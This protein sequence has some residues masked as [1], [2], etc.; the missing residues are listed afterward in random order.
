MKK[1]SSKKT[2]S[3]PRHN[4]ERE[5]RVLLEKMHSEIKNIG[6]G[7]SFITEK[8]QEI[9][10]T[11]Q[12]FNSTSFKIEMDVQAVKSKTGTIDIKTDRIE[13]ELETVKT[14]VLE[15]SKDIKDLK[16]GQDDIKHITA[17]HTERITKLE[18]V[19]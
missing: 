18:L 1:K 9:D 7:H 14:A 8:I 12:E 3:T 2:K 17:G 6:E 5:T 16:K 19:R 10:K 13:K 11:L 4:S 15:N